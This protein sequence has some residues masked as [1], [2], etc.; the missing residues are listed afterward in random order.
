MGDFD[1]FLNW[2]D[3]DRNQAGI[4]YEDIRRK[5]IR[6]FICRGCGVD[7]ETLA[8]ETIERVVRKYRELADR[9]EGE[10]LRYFYGVSRNV[11]RE[12][13]DEQVKIR[14]LQPLPPGDSSEEKERL[15][16]CLQKCMKDRPQ[17][18]QSLILEYYTGDKQQKIVNRKK[19]AERIGIAANALRIKAHRIRT[20]LRKCVEQ[21]VEDDQEGDK[22]NETNRRFDH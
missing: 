1:E 17:T 14:A 20:E 21:C 7:S 6:F 11:Y 4:R 2:L 9:Y 8:D 22:E 16:Q 18:D 3:P 12:W 5:L 15:D 10:P 19:L 13:L